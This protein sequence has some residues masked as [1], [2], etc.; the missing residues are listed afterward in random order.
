MASCLQARINKILTNRNIMTLHIGRFKALFTT[1]LALL[2]FISCVEN[3]D[4]ALLSDGKGYVML[5]LKPEIEI[6]STPK[7]TEVD[8]YNFRFVGVGDYGTSAYYRYGDVTWPME[9][10]FGIFRLQAESCTLEEA[11]R[12]YGTIRYEGVSDAFSVVNGQTA[13]TYVVCRI[14][15]VRVAV[16]FDD[17]MFIS[18]KNFRLEVVSMLAPVY[19]EDAEGNM[20]MVSDELPVRSLVFDAVNKVGYYNLSSSDMLLKYSLQV[21]MDGAD[22]YVEVLT[23]YFTENEDGPSLLKPGNYITFNVRYTGDVMVT[24]DIKFIVSGERKSISNEIELEDYYRDEV[25]EDE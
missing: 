24:E 22:E 2:L 8:N 4:N 6:K 25:T 23:G 15:N 11:E 19:E 7:S 14:A 1:A 3:E 12:D 20:N 18:F 9:W 17:K 10:Y 5:S 21:M 16:N 13:S